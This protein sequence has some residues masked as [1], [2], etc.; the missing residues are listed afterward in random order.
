LF[1]FFVDFWS[2]WGKVTLGCIF[3][4]VLIFGFVGGLEIA[5]LSLAMTGFFLGYMRCHI[6]DIL[7]CFFVDFWSF[8]G[9]V[10]LGC[11]FYFILIFG[12]GGGFEI[13]TLSLAM[14]VFF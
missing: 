3:Y 10:T 5:T 13:A 11:I 12:F 6:L 8:G 2:F 7:F 9:K 14:T 4:F 1:C